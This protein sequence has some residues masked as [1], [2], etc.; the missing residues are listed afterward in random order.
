MSD[1]E[2]KR[3]GNKLS[4]NEIGLNIKFFGKDVTEYLCLSCLAKYF[5]VSEELLKE[6]IEQFRQ[7][8]CVLFV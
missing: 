2:C 3:C 5:S 8:G 7:S 1:S 6:K 4:T